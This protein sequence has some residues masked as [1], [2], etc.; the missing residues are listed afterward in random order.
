M[1]GTGQPA[2]AERDP[3]PSRGAPRARNAV[4]PR[5]AVPPRSAV[6][7]RGS[8][9]GWLAA[10]LVSAALIAAI[11]LRP[12]PSGGGAGDAA[13]VAALP[14][15]AQDFV[16][17]ALAVFLESLPF[18]VLGTLISI[19]VRIWVPS[20]VLERA[21]PRRP[22]LRRLALSLFGI[23]LPVCECGNVPLAR[24]LLQR[25]CAPAEA[26]TFLL[27]A[28]IL[29]PVTILTTA[30]AFG[31]GSEILWA[32]VLGGF[33][34]ANLLGWWLSTHPRPEALLTPEFRASCAHPPGDAGGRLARSADAFLAETSQLMPALALGAVLAGA[35]QVGVPR[36][37]LLA[38]GA[39]PLWSVI[40][41]LVLA[42][43]ISLCATVDAFF[44]L[45]VS[46]AFLPG[47]VVA[48]LLFGA[49]MDVKMIVLLRTTFTG[50][51]VA[52]LAFLTALCVAAIAWGM[53]LAA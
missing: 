52:Q 29:N 53:N 20:G 8:A 21:L 6:R 3:A 14:A 47:S 35:I 43:I 39:D 9:A 33:V 27:A 18:V 4:H 41:L 13:A 12:G 28:P 26:V 38:L 31:W 10:G 23:V 19:A 49:L 40:A 24:G 7:P 2:A 36:G 51:A 50:R 42:A 32:R 15:A 11:V 45:S 37:A 30:H 44:I 46:A 25:G 5:S 16:T 22:A 48:F 34:I 1:S 17:L